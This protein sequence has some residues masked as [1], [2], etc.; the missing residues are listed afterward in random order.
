MNVAYAVAV[1]D[2]DD[3]WGH[4]DGGGWSGWMWMWGPLMMIFWIAVIGVAVWLI[5]RATGGTGTG[6]GR[7]PGAPESGGAGDTD[8]TGRARGILAERYARGEISTE[9]YEERLEKLR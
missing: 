9:E 5:V 2:P 4:M 6:T 8:G 7:G 3:R 1:A